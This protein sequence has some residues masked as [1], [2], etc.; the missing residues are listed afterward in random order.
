[1]F[2]YVAAVVTGYS[3]LWIIFALFTLLPLMVI[4][5]WFWL[6]VRQCCNAVI[7][8]DVILTSTVGLSPICLHKFGKNR[9]TRAGSIKLE[10]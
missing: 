7:M 2:D 3:L 1:M 9:S 10:K 5:H 8:Y 6:K 4:V